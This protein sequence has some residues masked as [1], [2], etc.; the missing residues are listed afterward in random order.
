MLARLRRDPRALELALA[1]AV[2]HVG[3]RRVA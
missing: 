1:A 3:S 2:E